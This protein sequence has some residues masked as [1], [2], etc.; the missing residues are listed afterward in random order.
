MIHLRRLACCYS[1]RDLCDESLM[2][3]RSSTTPHSN[4]SNTFKSSTDQKPGFSYVNHASKF[5]LSDRTWTQEGWPDGAIPDIKY[6]TFCVYFYHMI[7]DEIIDCKCMTFLIVDFILPTMKSKTL[8]YFLFCIG[9]WYHNIM[10]LLLP[11]LQFNDYFTIDLY[12][13]PCDIVGWCLISYAYDV[14]MTIW[15]YY[16][17]E[18]MSDI[19]EEIQDHNRI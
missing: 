2:T 17:C 15:D 13:I 1:W 9:L 8:K 10:I 19:I 4:Y 18:T 12:D 3:R 7:S 6:I 16:E 14:I 11:D 5:K